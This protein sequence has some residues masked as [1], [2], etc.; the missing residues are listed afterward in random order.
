MTP[1]KSRRIAQQIAIHVSLALVLIGEAIALNAQLEQLNFGGPL[2]P[3]NIE[4][5][6]QM[7]WVAV[8]FIVLAI[9]IGVVGRSLWIAG[10]LF[11]HSAAMLLWFNAGWGST[12][13]PA[14]IAL[15]TLWI[16]WTVR[17]RRRPETSTS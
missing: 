4:G 3:R 7:I 8:A 15:V 5:R 11:I 17:S 16:V 12:V 1:P 10:T 13:G 2:T 9:I 14:V 6:T